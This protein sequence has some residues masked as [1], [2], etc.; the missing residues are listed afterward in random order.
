M[1]THS[2][3]HPRY[4]PLSMGIDV[5][6]PAWPMR[7][8][9]AAGLD[10]DLGVKVVGSTADVKYT[11]EMGAFKL[12]VDWATIH[13]NGA[14][15]TKED[16]D[17]SK[18]FE[19]VRGYVDFN[20]VLANIT[21]QHVGNNACYGDNNDGAVQ[22]RLA[23][24]F[25]SRLGKAAATATVSAKGAGAVTSAKSTSNVCPLCPECAP[26]PASTRNSGDNAHPRVC[27]STSKPPESWGL[28]T[29]NDMVD[30]SAVKVKGVGGD[31]FWPPS[32]NGKPESRN[33]SAVTIKGPVDRMIHPSC[34]ASYDASNLFGGP[35]QAHSWGDWIAD[36]YHEAN[37]SAHTNIVWS[38]GALDPWS[39]GGH[40]RDPAAGVMGAA[41]QNLTADGSSIALAIQLGGHHLDLYFPTPGDPPTVKYARKVEQAMIKE[42]C[43]KHYLNLH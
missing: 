22:Q 31:A 20:G 8:G 1:H 36:Y 42:W 21:G 24:H 38:N 25:A 16:I 2:H 18:V 5:P 39:G 37:Q 41:L 12:D 27:N 40:Y 9:C 23:A 34:T 3:S 4:I 26:C 7:V 11:V 19:L 6:F 17:A 43:R 28:I 14:N 10:A 13:G 33:W 30:M 15:L 32:V 29:C 35:Q